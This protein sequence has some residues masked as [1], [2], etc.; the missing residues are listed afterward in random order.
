MK[1]F[2][3]LSGLLILTGCSILPTVTSEDWQS[4]FTPQQHERLRAHLSAVEHIP[5]W[6]AQGRFAARNGDEAWTGHLLWKQQLDD[7]FVR[8]S[9]PLG[10]GGVMLEG[11]RESASI[12]LSRDRQFYADSANALIRQHTGLRLPV[13]ELQYWLKGQPAPWMRYAVHA[14]DEQ[15]RVAELQQLGWKVSYARYR[16]IATVSLPGKVVMVH[17][18]YQLRVVI[19]DWQI[20]S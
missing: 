13:E 19:R 10:Q 8:L 17:P 6:Q 15:G 4:R 18:E 5:Q 11:D 14:L 9:G 3:R 16:K 1:L 7:Y 20:P 12:R 2:W